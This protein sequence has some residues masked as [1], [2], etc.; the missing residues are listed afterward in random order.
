MSEPSQRSLCSDLNVSFPARPLQFPHH[1][2]YTTPAMARN[3]EVKK[4]TLRGGTTSRAPVP[5]R[6][7]RHVLKDVLKRPA[8]VS[9]KPAVLYTVDPL[10]PSKPA[11]RQ[12]LSRRISQDAVSRMTGVEAAN[13]MVELALIPDLLGKR[14]PGCTGTLGP[15]VCRNGKN[16]NADFAHRRCSVSACGT[17]GTSSTMYKVTAACMETSQNNT[18]FSHCE[19]EIDEVC[20]RKVRSADGCQVT[21]LRVL[22]AV[23][24]RA[25]QMVLMWLPDKPVRPNMTK[26]QAPISPPPISKDEVNML[27]LFFGRDCVVYTDGAKNYQDMKTA[28]QWQLKVLDHHKVSHTHL[29]F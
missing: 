26:P 25:R 11:S 12:P 16:K 10:P 19:V 2:S 6:R 13:K 15:F 8:C 21:F 7:S 1:G 9:K 24:R 23:E 14:H 4:R 5:L 20:I 29:Q 17:A 27:L 18:V 28:A 22:G 3:V